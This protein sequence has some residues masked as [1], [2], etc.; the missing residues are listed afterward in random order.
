MSERRYPVC[1][2]KDV[3]HALESIGYQKKSQKGSHVKMIKFYESEKHI[4][5][6]PLHKELDKGTLSSI[7]RKVSKYYPKEKLIEILK[8]GRKK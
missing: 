3:V 4:I 2:G 7:V 6:I 8:I 5:V 1:S